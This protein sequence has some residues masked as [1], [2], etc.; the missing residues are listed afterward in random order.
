MDRIV[1]YFIKGIF[2]YVVICEYDLGEEWWCERNVYT[3][4][5]EVKEVG[6]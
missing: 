2:Q 1:Y 4:N 6:I 3:R 5:G